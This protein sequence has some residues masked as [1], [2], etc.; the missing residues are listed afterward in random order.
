MKLTNSAKCGTPELNWPIAQLT[1]DLPIANGVTC[2]AKQYQN[3]EGDHDT[4]SQRRL[5]Q[6]RLQHM[7]SPRTDSHSSYRPGLQ[8]KKDKQSS[9][10]IRLTCEVGMY[11]T[12]GDKLS[13]L[14]SWYVMRACVVGRTR[15]KDT[16]TQCILVANP[17]DHGVFCVI[18]C[19]GGGV[20][21]T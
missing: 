3:Q 20:H 9:C 17:L 5:Q 21:V 11:V 15:T 10:R 2:S 16:I 13:L 7:S 19:W 1:L 14:L 18:S 6:R 12:V 8:V 4:M